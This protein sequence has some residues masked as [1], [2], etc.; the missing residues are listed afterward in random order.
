M[1]PGQREVMRKALQE[2]WVGGG[3]GSEERV[4]EMLD[5]EGD[6]D[7]AWEKGEDL[8]RAIAFAIEKVRGQ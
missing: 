5:I 1:D 4:V 3:R 6:H 7:D 2:E 8:A